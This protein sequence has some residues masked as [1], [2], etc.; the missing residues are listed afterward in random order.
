MYNPSPKQRY[1]VSLEANAGTPVAVAAGAALG[2]PL[3]ALRTY[4]EA[5][6]TINTS[7]RLRRIEVSSTAVNTPLEGMRVRVVRGWTIAE[8]ATEGGVQIVP[9]NVQ[10]WARAATAV[11]VTN[12]GPLAAVTEGGVSL[13]ST[14]FQKGS[15]PWVWEAKTPDEGLVCN[16]GSG[17]VILAHPTESTTMY[18]TVT[19][20][21]I[22]RKA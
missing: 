18:A 9:R 2:S 16:Q 19:F 4:G 1:T 11:A 3:I 13:Y 20:E 22:N 15:Q 6:A 14:S 21:E 10:P 7:V 5:G 12:A 8:A 17:L